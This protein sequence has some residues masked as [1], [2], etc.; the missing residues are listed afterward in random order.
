MIQ[1]IRT[2]LHIAAKQNRVPC[3]SGLCFG[4]GSLTGRDKNLRFPALPPLG[5][6]HLE[7]R[8]PPPPITQTFDKKF[9]SMIFKAVISNRANPD[10]GQ[11]TIP[12]PIPDSEYDRTIGLPEGMGSDPAAARD[13]RAGVLAKIS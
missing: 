3:L 4:D 12:F 2:K 9:F 11:T 6:S 10:F 1:A 7:G 8:H 13:C 5:F